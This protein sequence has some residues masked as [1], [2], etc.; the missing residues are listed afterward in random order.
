[1][2]GDEG[3]HEC[4]TDRQTERVMMPMLTEK[5]RDRTKENMS[6]KLFYRLPQ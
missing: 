3:L 6:M 2:E 1:M 5:E 4:H